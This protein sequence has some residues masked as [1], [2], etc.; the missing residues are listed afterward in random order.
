MPDAGY[1]RDPTI[2]GDTVVFVC[3]DDLWTVPARGGVA[4]RLTANPGPVSSPMLSPDGAW[5][6]YMGRDE[7]TDEVYVMPAVGGPARRL[8]YFGGQSWVVGWTPDG[9]SIVVASNA[10]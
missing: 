9:T 8:S 6:A 7:G 2:N 1:Y 3:E 5:I 4:R 10:K